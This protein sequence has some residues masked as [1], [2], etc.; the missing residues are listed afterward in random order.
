[1]E[2]E[3]PIKYD[4][5]IPHNCSTCGSKMKRTTPR[6][7]LRYFDDGNVMSYT[8]LLK[9]KKLTGIRALTARKWEHDSYQVIETPYNEVNTLS[10][11]ELIKK[12]I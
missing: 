5:P 10:Y 8:Y 11:R 6:S 12:P 7:V 4:K 3:Q 9:C 2:K 1:M